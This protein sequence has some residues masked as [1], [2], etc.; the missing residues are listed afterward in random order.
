MEIKITRQN[1]NEIL[2]KL[3]T[4]EKVSQKKICEATGIA[5]STL[6]EIVTNKRVPTAVTVFK[7]NKYFEA[8]K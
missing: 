2:L 1:A 5:E 8:L 4:E 7:L 6:S 3:I